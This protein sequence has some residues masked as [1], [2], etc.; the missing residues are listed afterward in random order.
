MD[1]L[2][3]EG[4]DTA[5]RE[6]GENWLE[7]TIARDPILGR[8]FPQLRRL[9][10]SDAPVLISGEPGSGRELAAR[11]IHNLSHRAAHPFVVL[12]CADFSEPLIEAELV[13][14]NG[15]GAPRKIGVFEQAG[16]G[17]VH[18]SEVSELPP[19]GQEA[20]LRLL[21]RH[22]IVRLGSSAPVA[23]HARCIASTSV[24]LRARIPAGLFREELHGRLATEVLALPPL[25]ERRDDIPVLAQH[26]LQQCCAHLPPAAREI[27]R[28]AEAVLR[29]YHWAR[30]L[31]E[32]REAIEEAAMRARGQRIA[33]EHL[34]E[35]IRRPEERGPLPSLRDVEMRHIQRVLEEARGNQRRASRILGISR[36]S[37]SRRLRK[38]NMQPR[39]EQE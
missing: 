20:L 12:D 4:S 3:D 33:V 13:G 8:I 37:L 14:M 24:D 18:L 21:D 28:E 34:P 38:Y 32:L 15:G 5:S 25:R 31:R 16:E 10:A 9:A 17:S 22:E 29:E 26:Y 35:R 27:S 6:R 1:P 19:R 7:D 36:W 39:Q 23:A 30:N 2:Q 11:A